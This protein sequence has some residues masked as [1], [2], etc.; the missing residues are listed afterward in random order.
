M[1]FVRPRGDHPV[2]GR[3]LE[4]RGYYVCPREACLGL[5]GKRLGRW[6]TSAEAELLVAALRR[7]LEEGTWIRRG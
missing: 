3:L 1:R 2:V 7:G 5:L 6:F 4:G